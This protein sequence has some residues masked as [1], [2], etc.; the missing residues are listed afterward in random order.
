MKYL[1]KTKKFTQDNL[2][3]LDECVLA[4]LEL[5]STHEINNLDLSRFKRPLIAG[6]GNAIVT[7]EI[8]F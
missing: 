6:S 8:I 2:I 4:A 3:A 1:E 5:F 7:A